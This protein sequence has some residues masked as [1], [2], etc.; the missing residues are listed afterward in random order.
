MSK[1]MPRPGTRVVIVGRAIEQGSVARTR[2]ALASDS[3][4]STTS[5]ALSP[6]REGSTLPLQQLDTLSVLTARAFA[7]LTRHIW[8][9]PEED[10]AWADW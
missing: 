2:F 9:T 8:D 5:Y 1:V 6:S 3:R 10:E 7:E 4:C